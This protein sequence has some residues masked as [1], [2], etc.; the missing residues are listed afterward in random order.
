MSKT[1]PEVIRRRAMVE[2]V[3]SGRPQQQVARDFGVSPAT[4]NRSVRHAH[5]QRLDRVDW[6][7]R[8]P[9]SLTT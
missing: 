2:V 8:S 9:I 5:G 6:F 7:D 3:R 1:V 4:V